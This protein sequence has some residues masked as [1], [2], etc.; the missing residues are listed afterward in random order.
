MCLVIEPS[1]KSMM[2]HQGVSIARLTRPS[3]IISASAS[4]MLKSVHKFDHLLRTSLSIAL[5]GLSVE[6]SFHV[7]RA[8]M[9]TTRRDA[10]VVIRPFAPRKLLVCR[11]QRR[12]C[13]MLPNFED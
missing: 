11:F 8:D 13:V 12:L 4:S 10:V 7:D 6:R 3:R 9:M 5:S 2:R 1:D